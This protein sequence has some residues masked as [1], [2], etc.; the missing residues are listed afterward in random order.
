MMLPQ[1]L[2]VANLDL[3]LVENGTYTGECDNN[4]VKVTVK[5]TV[6]DHIVTD[7]EILNQ[8]NGKG[9]AAEVI[10]TDVL[11]QQSLQVD[12]VASATYSNN[13]ILKAIENALLQGIK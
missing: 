7:I 3:S 9:Q 8:Q 4:I 11:E 10:I 12:A 6:F 13:T 2:E 5:V 1:K